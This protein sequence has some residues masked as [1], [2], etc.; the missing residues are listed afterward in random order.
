MVKSAITTDAPAAGRSAFALR[1]ILPLAVLA[2]GLAGFFAFRLD[3]YLSLSALADNRD[4]LLAWVHES[5]TVAPLAFVALYAVAVA[6]S[7]PG[8]TV[9][10]IAGGFLFGTLLGTVYAVVGATIG[11]AAVFLAARTAFAEP[12]RA[13]AGPMLSKVEAGFRENATSYLLFL[14]LVP[15]FPF[16]LVNLVP[17]FLGVPFRTYVT[18]TI[19]GILPGTAVYSSVGNGLGMLVDQGRMPDLG[20][21]TK[22]EILLPLVA[23]SL[24]SLVP[25]FYKWLKSR[26]QRP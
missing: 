4:A 9:L 12:L 25:V 16:W 17:A 11:A 19:V 8:G 6:T 10:T 26:K 2:A 3:R 18:T 21:I 20:L 24:L 23:L 14:R 1:R 15:L 13:R 22:P 7:V 5:G